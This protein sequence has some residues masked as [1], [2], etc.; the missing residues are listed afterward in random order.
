MYK[1][2]R[3]RTHSPNCDLLNFCPIPKANFWPI[4]AAQKCS[5]FT[6][7][8]PIS[9][10]IPSCTNTLLVIGQIRNF[11]SYVMDGRMDRPTEGQ[12]PSCRDVRTHL[13]I[14]RQSYW[15]ASLASWQLV[16][17]IYIEVFNA[18]LYLKDPA[19]IRIDR[20]DKTHLEMCCEL[21]SRNIWHGIYG[22]TNPC[23]GDQ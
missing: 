17:L 13:K 8:R 23:F 22:S 2:A 6:F 18:E 12:T 20:S 9:C 4:L 3:E 11:N 10:H 21:I 7:F 16:M 14:A 15:W 5:F 1:Y 19:L